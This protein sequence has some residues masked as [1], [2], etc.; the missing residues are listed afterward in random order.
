MP[1]KMDPAELTMSAWA[2]LIGTRADVPGDYLPFLDAHL[3]EGRTLPYMVLTP[4][5]EFILRPTTEKLI[6]DFGRE[7]SVLE[8]DGRDVTEVEYPIQGISY[9]EVKTVLL[10]SR[11]KICGLTDLI[12]KISVIW[13]IRAINST[14]MQIAACYLEKE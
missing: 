4:T 7:I 6:L 12:I 1:P 10:D 3:S 14:A 2:K 8:R 13:P 5:R 9:V 11:I